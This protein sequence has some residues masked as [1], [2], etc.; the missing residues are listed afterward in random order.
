[1]KSWCIGLC[2]HA[3][4]YHCLYLFERLVTSFFNSPLNLLF[5]RYVIFVFLSLQLWIDSNSHSWIINLAPLEKKKNP[6]KH[7]ILDDT[8]QKR[9][10]SVY[11]S[12][13]RRRREMER[14]KNSRRI[15]ANPAAVFSRN[16]SY[17]GGEWWNVV[18]DRAVT[19]PC[20]PNQP[21]RKLFEI[22]SARS[23]A[24]SFA[25]QVKTAARH[26]GWR[27]MKG[28]KKVRAR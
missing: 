17:L 6:F 26:R 25:F 23:V 8:F 11:R 9:S 3:V 2:R 12:I 18:L 24:R 22:R 21:W 4:L 16:L 7:S 28:E 19:Q 5:L 14:K 15:R 27:R 20:R 1:M 10:R 13:K